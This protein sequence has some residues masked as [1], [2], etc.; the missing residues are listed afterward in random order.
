MSSTLKPVN[1]ATADAFVKTFSDHQNNIP[2]GRFGIY[3]VSKES[4]EFKDYRK[5]VLR[6]LDVAIKYMEDRKHLRDQTPHDVRVRMGLIYYS[7]AFFLYTSPNCELQ[8]NAHGLYDICG[9]SC[10]HLNDLE[11]IYKCLIKSL[12]LDSS[13]ASNEKSMIILERLKQNVPKKWK[14]KCMDPVYEQFIAKV[15]R[16]AKEERECYPEENCVIL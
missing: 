13:Y 1:K 14:S 8:C 2:R 5:A 3:V 15:F 7:K 4:G 16:D 9:K 6:D 10:G 11:Q 12:K